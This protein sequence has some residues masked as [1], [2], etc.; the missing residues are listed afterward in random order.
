LNDRT[1]EVSE[2]V[3][4]SADRRG[5]LPASKGTVLWILLAITLMLGIS[6]GGLRWRLHRQILQLQGAA[7][8]LA[9]GFVAGRLTAPRP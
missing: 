9:V 6:L 4:E 3:S 1:P 5:L 2:V 7:L 8:G